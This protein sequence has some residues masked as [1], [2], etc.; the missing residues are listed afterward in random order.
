MVKRSRVA[1]LPNT[2]L[3]QW[4]AHWSHSLMGISS[5][6]SSHLPTYSRMKL[7]VG[8]GKGL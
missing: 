3:L 6:P 7:E 5:N 4:L 1:K 8:V 2:G